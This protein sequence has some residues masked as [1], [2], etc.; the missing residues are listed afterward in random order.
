[1]VLDQIVDAGEHDSWKADSVRT[2]FAKD[3]L[4]GILTILKLFFHT[5]ALNS[6]IHTYTAN[7]IKKVQV[8]MGACPEDP[9]GRGTRRCRVSWTL[10]LHV[11]TLVSLER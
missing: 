9:V 11:T 10:S 5:N 2:C 7:S 8:K 6:C 4:A 3:L 1:M